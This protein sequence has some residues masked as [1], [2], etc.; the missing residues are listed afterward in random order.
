[1]NRIRGLFL[2]LLRLGLR[3]ILY[4]FS[5]VLLLG[6]ALSTQWAQDW[7]KTYAV[8]KINESNYAVLELEEFRFSLLSGI[9]LKS[10]QVKLPSG[11]NLSIAEINLEFLPWALLSRRIAVRKI[12]IFDARLSLKNTTQNPL[13]AA[14]DQPISISSLL[15]LFPKTMP[16]L[17]VKYVEVESYQ[18]NGFSLRFLPDSN[19]KDP[20]GVKWKLL[21]GEASYL[22]VNSVP[23]VK[24]SLFAS[25]GESSFLPLKIE[26]FKIDSILTDGTIEINQLLLQTKESQLQISGT[27]EAAKNRLNLQLTAD[28]FSLSEF[29]EMFPIEKL[30]TSLQSF[31]FLFSVKGPPEE[32][33]FSGSLK[34]GILQLQTDG[35]LNLSNLRLPAY[36]IRT[37]FSKI[38]TS[39]LTQGVDNNLAGWRPEQLN[40]SVD[41]RG[42]G[43]K[44]S[45]MEGSLAIGLSPG[46]QS[47]I[48]FK[49][50]EI[51]AEVKRGQVTVKEGI[52]DSE[53]GLLKVEGMFNLAG[54]FNLA[55]SLNFRITAT[56]EK[57][58]L[59][60]I[61]EKKNW[62][63]Q[64]NF[65]FESEGHRKANLPWTS[66]VAKL[67][68]DIMPSKVGPVALNRSYIK[69]S[70][71]N[72]KVEIADLNIHSQ[73]NRLSLQGSVARDRHIDLTYKLTAKDFQLLSLFY[74]QVQV[75][76]E[77]E[78]AG[79]LKGI[80]PK[81]SVDGEIK[82]RNFTT[83]ELAISD[84]IIQF[85]AVK[86][87]D[88]P[89]ITTELL[90]KSVD[91]KKFNIDNLKASLK[92]G[93]KKIDFNVSAF[94]KNKAFINLA[95]EGVNL[96][97]GEKEIVFNKVELGYSGTSWKNSANINLKIS[98]KGVSFP[99][100]RLVNPPQEMSFAG[101]VSFSGLS[102]FQ[103]LGNQLDLSLFSAYQLVD[104]E[105]QGKVNIKASWNGAVQ[106]PE[107]ESTITAHS[108]KYGKFAWDGLD[109]ELAY[110]QN[111]LN[112]F[113]LLSNRKADVLYVN[114]FIDD[115]ALTN[116]SD[117]LRKASVSLKIKSRELDLAVFSP[118]QRELDSLEGLLTMDVDIEGSLFSPDISGSLQVRNGRFPIPS[119]NTNLGR[120]ETNIAQGEG[121][122]AYKGKAAVQASLG[123]KRRSKKLQLSS[124]TQ[125]SAHDQ[126]KRSESPSVRISFQEL[127][128][129]VV[130]MNFNDLTEGELLLRVSALE[131][132]QRK[133][134]RLRVQGKGEKKG[135]LFEVELLDNDNNGANAQA[136]IHSF[137]G[138]RPNRIE[139]RDVSIKVRQRRLKSEGQIDIYL[140]N[141]FRFNTESF[142]IRGAYEEFVLKGQF[143]DSEA[144]LEIETRLSDIPALTEFLEIKKSVSVKGGD[145]VFKISIKG[146]P[147]QPRIR[148]S[149]LARAWEVT[150]PSLATKF[151]LENVRVQFSDSRVELK[152]LILKDKNGSI[153]IQGYADIKGF[154]I[155]QIKLEAAIKDFQAVDSK[156]YSFQSSGEVSISGSLTQPVIQGELMLRRGR[157]NLRKEYETFH[158]E[159]KFS[160]ETKQE[161][162]VVV[163]K[164]KAK[165]GFWEAVTLNIKIDVPNNF[166]IK[167]DNYNLELSGGLVL[168]KEPQRPMIYTGSIST[169]KGNY[170]LYG[171]NFTFS[172]GTVDFPG[173]SS[174]NPNL[175][176]EAVYRVSKVQISI[177]VRGTVNKPEI[178]F[179]SD[180][181]MP[182]TEIFSYLA[183]GKA[184]SQLS[185]RE[186]SSFQSQA[187]SFLGGRVASQ[188]KDF[189]G[190]K[191]SL[192]TVEITTNT[193]K[194]VAGGTAQVG[195]YLSDNLYLQYGRT[196]GAES[197]NKMNMEYKMGKY[198]TLESEVGD[199]G[200]TGAD[201]IF[202]FDY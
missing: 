29:K 200:E 113:A 61:L 80:W 27:I 76:G 129:A 192:D 78:G 69:A 18:I 40:L 175:N 187:A 25:A 142:R 191:F 126:E 162:K 108:L 1:M 153:I 67:K 189:F 3:V 94:L 150:V 24:F 168:L 57:V 47:E 127:S 63:S 183:F 98:E 124:E 148:G 197:G 202:N 194:G 159:I 92:L 10:L 104:E 128:L 91:Y 17:P 161:G 43:L 50:T 60:A 9:R 99:D 190:E 49:K 166:W 23:K 115:L 103:L 170:Q 118:L 193:E 79:S 33:S 53:A 145:F 56:G 174:L 51:V 38:E 199:K 138:F 123:S 84:G 59:A 12:E 28:P 149:A 97:A 196:F 139:I 16:V 20:Q 2:S 156:Q 4:S 157:V 144:D 37:Q 178:T 54:L 173:I 121:N 34:S 32:F 102:Q 195:K 186:A 117:S 141:G 184:S 122:S 119:K 155:D 90:L 11:D 176:V 93:E 5:L 15:Q 39:L 120:N 74:P 137:T 36:S 125:V 116:L 131:I 111:Q 19:E 64:L 7:I 52:L 77:V 133:L 165:S 21:K 71:R 35:T 154:R 70:Y 171:K 106:R 81:M 62:E 167:G 65:R 177:L 72:G 109:L 8:A 22:T 82:I 180:P 95:G 110:Q 151:T 181:P 132:D 58:D 73:N 105:I 87:K 164:E 114:A 188:L 45:E 75:A 179:Q 169:I 44:L 100:F 107:I 31:V 130:R 146:S 96:F 101:F 185:Q 134:G 198:F 89:G 88:E 86:T 30:P 41:F 55:E 163:L 140:L 147:D 48:K 143:A 83:S 182:E 6:L 13:P 14:D 136:F 42:Q 152:E 26:L 201:I 68:A 135:W 112:L 66:L 85:A 46:G 160:G 172:E 158:P